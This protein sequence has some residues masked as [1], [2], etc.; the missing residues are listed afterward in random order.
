MPLERFASP[1]DQRSNLA[2]EAPVL[3]CLPFAPRSGPPAVYP[4]ALQVE[5]VIMANGV[6]QTKG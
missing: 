5:V 6:P 3:D 1:A 4:V 2:L